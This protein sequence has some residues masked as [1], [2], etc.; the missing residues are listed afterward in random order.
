MLTRVKT[1]REV[2]AMRAGGKIL[3]AVLNLVSSQVR[4]GVTAAELDAM[5]MR[6]LKARKAGAAFL[7]FRGFPASICVSINEEV[8]HGIPTS[9]KTV[10]SG[11]VVSLDLGVAYEGMIVDSATTVIAGDPLPPDDDRQRLISVTQDSLGK[12][13]SAVRSG[14]R[15][16]DISSAIQKTLE[17]T[18][19][20]VVKELVGHGVGHDLHEE[21]N[22][23][24]FGRRGS[25]MRLVSGMTIA[26]EPMAALGKGGVYIDKDGWTVKT[27]DSSISAQ[28]EHTVLVTDTGYEILTAS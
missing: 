8:V 19:L 14:C 12:G 20:G 17:S 28:F 13:I 23:P 11:D 21:P 4:P 16:G 15:V 5:A 24:N 10:K 2:D 9:D 26:I 18:G 3:A 6:E 22:I 7:G 25:G 27:K 1:K